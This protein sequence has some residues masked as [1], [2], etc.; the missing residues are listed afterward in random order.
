V[1]GEVVAQEGL[2]L[3]QEEIGTHIE[4]VSAQWGV[5]ADD[6]R[7]SLESDT[8]QQV[9]RSQLLTDKA[10]QRLVAIAKGEAPELASTT[11]QEGNEAEEPKAGSEETQE[12][13]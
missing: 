8:G 11:E 7:S 9:V 4:A 12:E 3:D 2:D 13:A 6:V 1:L 10:I 5:R